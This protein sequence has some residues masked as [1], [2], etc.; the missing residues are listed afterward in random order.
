MAIASAVRR[1]HT[2][3]Q[4]AKY[5]ESQTAKLPS[6]T[7]LWAAV[8]AIG[9]SATLSGRGRPRLVIRSRRDA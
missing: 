3:G 4:I 2:E 6:D 9:E 5:I 7:F 1:Q 8:A